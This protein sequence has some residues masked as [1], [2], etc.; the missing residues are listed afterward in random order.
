M[1]E[2]D[3]LRENALNYHSQSPA[4]KLEIRPTKPM[5]DQRDLSLAYSPG[6][7]YACEEIATNPF[8]ASKYTARGNLVAVVTNGT[9]V[10]GL[11]AIGALASKPVMEGKAVLF[12]KF[13]GI[14]VFDIEI[15]ETDPD[16]FIE[17]VVRL[18]PTFGAINLE[19]IK[20]PECFYIEEQ[21]RKRMK[22]PV[23]HDD[24]HG[25]AICVAA[26]ALN[27]TQIVNKALED[28][29]L[30]TSGAGAAAMACVDLLAAMGVKDENIWLTD[31]DGVIYE[32]REPNMNA[33]HSRYAKLTQ[34]R[35]LS[36]V[37]AGADIF[38][39]LSAPNVLKPE[40]VAAMAER[41]II[42][43]LANPTPEIM[44]EA[45]RNVRDDVIIA[46]GRSDYPN[47]VNNVLCFPFIFR[48]ALDCGAIE[49]NE[50]MK[51]SC[52]RAI[53]DLAKSE[54]T[55]QVLAAYPGETFRIGPDY[56]IPKPFDPRL[57]EAVPKA[58]A[59]A[60]MESGV[61]QKPIVDLESYGAKLANIVDRSGL[62]MRPVFMHAKANDH[63]ILFTE[64]EA[65]R[66]LMATQVIAD[67]QLA[68]PV[69][70]GRPEIMQER[71]DAIGLRIQPGI[72]FEVID[73]TDR[74]EL[75]RLE[76]A[77]MSAL[78]RKGQNHMT[79]EA[80]L[81]R[82]P[83]VHGCLLLKSGRVDGMVCGAVGGYHSHLGTVTDIIGPAKG[84]RK[85]YA[86][87]G[88]V[89]SQGLMFFGDTQIHES[90][91]AE[92][93]AELTLLAAECAG[94]FGVIPRVALLSHSTFGTRSHLSSVAELRTALDLIH[95]RAPNLE[96]DGEMQF[97]IAMSQSERKRLYP[98]SLLKEQANI[99][100]SSNVDAS[101]I[102]HNVGRTFGG[103]PSIG[104]ILLGAAR[105][106]HIVKQT[107]SVRGLI[108][109]AALTSHDAELKKNRT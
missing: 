80:T 100:I 10:L 61:A 16:A 56:I 43:A 46:T 97:D 87:G 59:R 66:I 57:I 71:I 7:A 22:I 86:L 72:Q 35:S 39:G 67:E 104:P 79:V 81:R 28:I 24:Q 40:Y 19:D 55:E 32:G 15:D 54:P 45:A 37:I 95:E 53:A 92:D 29:T 74:N 98:N 90:L 6:V 62:A 26:A 64:G 93:I 58:V 20:A 50:A 60:A 103:G 48:G 89:S 101:N 18:E 78:E 82:K 23:F 99:F 5:G 4:G 13:A 73:P 91:T 38:L 17:T 3:K 109:L 36:D 47:Q 25:T 85:L 52:V 14:D 107:V 69:L 34:A 51:I 33:R 94:Q 49:I 11:G 21:L 44:P 41:P 83:T 108:N 105:P 76:D 30:V 70:L 106:V 77:F 75:L 84:V 96:I 63:R 12:K 8:C 1:S 27:G 102:A 9:A 68:R 88:L 2:V 42:L 31:I 65:D